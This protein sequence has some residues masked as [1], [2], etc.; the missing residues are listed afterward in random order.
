MTD[1]DLLELYL[2]DI[3]SRPTL[4]NLE[5][6]RRRWAA[7]WRRHPQVEELREAYRK[8]KEELSVK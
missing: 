2:S 7:E 4:A 5:E 6:L 8:K 3:A 1:A